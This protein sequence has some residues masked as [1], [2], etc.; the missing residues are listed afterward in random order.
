MWQQTVGAE[1]ST[2]PGIA[3]NDPVIPPIAANGVVYYATGYDSRVYAFD[4]ASG[5]YLW[6]SGY[7]A[8]GKEAPNRFASLHRHRM[9]EFR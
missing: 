5:N 8:T 7:F 2:V 4:A 1:A 6:D 3:G 9:M